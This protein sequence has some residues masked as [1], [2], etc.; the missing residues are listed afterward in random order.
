MVVISI[1]ERKGCS[2]DAWNRGPARRLPHNQVTTQGPPDCHRPEERS[3]WG[4]EAGGPGGG[5]S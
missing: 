5:Y 1:V 4:T 3:P 2:W